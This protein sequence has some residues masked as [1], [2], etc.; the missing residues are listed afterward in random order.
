MHYDYDYDND[1]KQDTKLVL[2]ILGRYLKKLVIV[3]PFFPPLT[4]FDSSR[5]V[6]HPVV[7][8]TTIPV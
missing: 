4:L 3:S 5:S 8:K 7:I 1:K 2:K 6:P